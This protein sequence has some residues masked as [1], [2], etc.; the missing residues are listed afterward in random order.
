MRSFKARIENR[1]RAKASSERVIT[2]ELN[3]EISAKDELDH[4]RKGLAHQLQLQ[5]K[6]ISLQD[7]SSAGQT[8]PEDLRASLAELRH[9]V[10]G[11]KA[12]FAGLT[13]PMLYN[14]HISWSQRTDESA[15]HEVFGMP[16]MLEMIL[17]YL[18][19]RDIFAFQQ[20]TSQA[21][22]MVTGSPRLQSLLFLRPDP[23]EAPFRQPPLDALAGLE[24]CRPCP[25]VDPTEVRVVVLYQKTRPKLGEN[26]RRMLVAQPPVHDMDLTIS[27]CNGNGGRQRNVTIGIHCDTGFRFGNL[28]D[29]A[30]Q[31]QMEHRHCPFAELD[32]HDEDGFVRPDVTFVGH[33][34]RLPLV[35]ALVA[36]ASSPWFRDVLV[37]GPTTDDF[38]QELHQYILHKQQ[39]HA[40]GHI[41]ETVGE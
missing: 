5:R 7:S 16:E 27:C 40:G 25:R 24:L 10:E 12:F 2:W 20:T 1:T 33:A 3:R 14:E 11:V 39:T 32:L 21:K 8:G 15:A 13:N 30:V 19:I 4:A 23:V 38:Q 31:K 18:S 36:G 28:L 6:I 37:P 26:Y 9:H 34:S 29:L 35:T 41:I 17:E 22:T